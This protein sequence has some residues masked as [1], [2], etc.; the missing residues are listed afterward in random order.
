[1][2]IKGQVFL[3]STII[4]IVILTIIELNFFNFYILNQKSSEIYS[5]EKDYIYNIEKEIFLSCSISNENSLENFIDFLNIE[6]N[7]LYSKNY[8]FNS[9]FTFVSYKSN[10]YNKINVTLI[11]YMNKDFNVEIYINST[12][13]QSDSISLQKNNIYSKL[14]DIDPEK[15]YILTIKYLEEFN[16]SISFKENDAIFVFGDIN[17]SSENINYIDKLQKTYYFT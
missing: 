3:I 15:D 10:N 16:M 8:D 2:G 12:P 4:I 5:Y 13:E 11:N 6:K 1:M 14:F 7:F 9:F 17:I